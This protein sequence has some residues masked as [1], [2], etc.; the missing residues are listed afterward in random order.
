M[1]GCTG[2]REVVVVGGGGSG[3][4]WVT[5]RTGKERECRV[6]NQEAELG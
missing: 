1:G 3:N 5:K 4:G 6:R 2:K